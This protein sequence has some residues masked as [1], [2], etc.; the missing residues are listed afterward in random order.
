M[1]MISHWFSTKRHTRPIYYKLKWIIPAI[2]ELNCWECCWV[3]E[4]FVELRPESLA[5]LVLVTN[6]LLS[7]RIW[8][9]RFKEGLSTEDNTYELQIQ[10]RRGRSPD[11]EVNL[12]DSSV[13]VRNVNETEGGGRHTSNSSTWTFQK[14][15]WGWLNV[16]LYC[17]NRGM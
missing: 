12:Q 4:V 3:F 17:K 10:G 9:C 5:F 11:Q 2:L 7:V 16:L 14:W 6:L 15:S 8:S 1:C 13:D